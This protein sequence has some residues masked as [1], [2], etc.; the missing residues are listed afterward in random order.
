[1]FH[2]RR[3]NERVNALLSEESI[4]NRRRQDTISLQM[5]IF[6]WAMEF[7]SG[8]FTVSFA[9]LRLLPSPPDGPIIY[10]I[11]F[12]IDYISSTILVPGCYIIKTESVKQK[13]YSL[14]WYQFCRDLLPRPNEVV[15]QS[16]NLE[17]SAAS[18]GVELGKNHA[19]D[20]PNLIPL[21]PSEGMQALSSDNDEN[22]LMR[23]DL[24][25]GLE[26]K[27]LP[28]HVESVSSQS[29]VVPSPIQ[30]QPLPEGVDGR[31]NNDDEN[32]LMRIDFFEDLDIIALPNIVDLVSNQSLGI[33]SPIQYHPSPKWIQ[34]QCDDNE[35][36]WL[37]RIDL[38]E[39]LEL[40]P[41]KELINDYLNQNQNQ[42]SCESDN[43]YWIDNVDN[44][45][46]E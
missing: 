5:T 6:A 27:A 42:S 14:G 18:N 13:V 38:F 34:E 4:R 22:W 8:L 23:I 28:N 45:Q 10:S 44:F 16:Q 11:M 25:D 19:E 31:Y 15:P 35:E 41:E 33:P 1:M 20:L 21:Q 46:D 3:A 26:M 37:M 24:F 12:T 9:L 40:Q 29:E 2:F 7:I 17:G 36:N 30:L 43:H 32:Y 39:D